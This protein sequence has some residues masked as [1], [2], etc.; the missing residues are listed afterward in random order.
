MSDP[1]DL[2]VKSEMPYGK[3]KGTPIAT[4]SSG[5]SNVARRSARR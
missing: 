3:Y 5:S 2:L 4:M 1:L